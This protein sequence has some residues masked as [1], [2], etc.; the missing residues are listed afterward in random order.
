MQNLLLYTTQDKK[1]K[2]ELYELGESIFLAQDSMAKLFAFAGLHLK[3]LCFDTSKQN[4]SL[5]IRNILQEG[6]LQE[7][8]VV[9]EYLTTANDGKTSKGA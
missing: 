2:V 8:S 9:K 4:I 1:V 3:K 5:H 7:D 6:E